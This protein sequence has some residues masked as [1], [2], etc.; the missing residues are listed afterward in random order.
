MQKGASRQ[1]SRF[2]KLQGAGNDLLVL[3]STQMPSRG[4]AEFVRAISHRQLGVG[5]DQLMEVTSRKPL[6]IQIWNNDGSKSEMCANG[7]RTFLFFAA[8]KKWI[9][10]KAAT[11]ALRVSGKPYVGK[12]IGHEKYEFSLGEPQIGALEEL[13]LEGSLIPFRAVI[14]G[15]PHAVIVADGP[16]AWRPPVGFDYKSTGPKIEVHPRF[17]KKTNVEFLRKITVK[18]AKA[19]A[20]VEVWERGAGA[21][22][23][24]G[25]GAVASAVVV[26]ALHPEVNVCII[27]MTQ[28]QLRIRFEG[29]AAFIS[30]PCA[31]VVS[32]T[33]FS[34]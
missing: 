27:R 5:C 10:P 25:S 2:Y 6:A 17:P 26:R 21:T 22:L 7:A 12:R 29:A 3:E 23:S 18:G 34:R 8:R 9:N 11:V 4:K 30:G 33:Y 19:E 20:L 31:L 28:F 1:G 13:Y 32:G 14:T 24:C 15:N 16:H